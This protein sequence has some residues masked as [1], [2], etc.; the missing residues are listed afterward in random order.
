MGDGDDRALE[1]VHRVLE[2]LGGLDVEVVGRLVEQQQVVALDLEA[3]DLQARALAAGERL[4]VR[5]AA[6]CRP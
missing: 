4:G 6:S 1:A 2:R 3:E 5:R